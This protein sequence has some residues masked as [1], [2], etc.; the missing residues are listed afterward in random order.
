M[1]TNAVSF[2]DFHRA[3]L[4]QYDRLAA[5]IR[6]YY[7]LTEWLPSDYEAC[8]EKNLQLARLHE[9]F[10]DFKT[11]WHRA[12]KVLGPPNPNAPC[13]KGLT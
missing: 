7:E 10:N 9:E 1:D 13:P 12:K 5:E 11:Q 4:A 8:E 6:K 3:M 2:D